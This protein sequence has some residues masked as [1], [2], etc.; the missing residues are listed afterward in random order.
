LCLRI[1]DLLQQLSIHLKTLF[2]QKQ[3]DEGFTNPAS[4]AQLQLLNLCLLKTTLKREKDGAMILK[5]GGLL[6]GNS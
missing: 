1:T 6:I 2:P 5:P 4:T 3:S